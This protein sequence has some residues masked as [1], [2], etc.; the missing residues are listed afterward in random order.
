MANKH[1][2]FRAAAREK[3]LRGAAALADAVRLTLGPRSKCVLIGKKWGRPVVCNDGIACTTDAC[4]PRTG[5]CTVTP[6]NAACSDGL[7]CN[8]VEVCNPS[9]GCVAGTPVICDDDIDCTVDSCQEPNG[10]CEVTPVNAACSD[11]KLCNGAESCVAGVGC[12]AGQPYVCPSSSVSCAR[13]ATSSR[14]PRSGTVT[15]ITP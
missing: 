11:G 10:T 14:A 5:Q 6:N 15:T 12:T 9:T 7:A 4:D 2:L 13:R 8:G 3:V 1:L